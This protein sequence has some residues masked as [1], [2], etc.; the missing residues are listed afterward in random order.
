MNYY[1]DWCGKFKISIW[2]FWADQLKPKTICRQC[3]E[4]YKKDW[5]EKG[6]K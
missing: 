5:L 4:C 6:V 3:W 2:T 1:C